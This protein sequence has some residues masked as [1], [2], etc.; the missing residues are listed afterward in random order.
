MWHRLFSLKSTLFFF[1]FSYPSGQLDLLEGFV[2]Q[3]DKYS[4]TLC[5]PH[6]LIVWGQQSLLVKNNF[7]VSL[8]KECIPKWVNSTRMY[9]LFNVR[10]NNCG[11]CVLISIFQVCHTSK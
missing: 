4:N 3:S 7:V 6:C 10:V 9:Y 2:V 11:F 8:G 1:F 5:D